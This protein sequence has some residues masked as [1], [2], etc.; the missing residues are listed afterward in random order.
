MIKSGIL[1]IYLHLYSF[2]RSTPSFPLVSGEATE[3][4]K[5]KDPVVAALQSEL[6]T[7]CMPIALVRK[8][9]T[10]TLNLS[11]NMM[12]HIKFVTIGTWW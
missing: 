4:E 8:Y 2:S 9:H 5:E 10:V 7:L 6:K 1:I 3:K 11:S 12:L